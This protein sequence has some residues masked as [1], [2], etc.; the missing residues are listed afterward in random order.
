MTKQ[1][2]TTGGQ[3]KFLSPTGREAEVGAVGRAGRWCPGEDGGGAGT[4]ALK[5]YASREK[6][7]NPK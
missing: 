3:N 5:H 4:P 2:P 6:G 1:E 7:F